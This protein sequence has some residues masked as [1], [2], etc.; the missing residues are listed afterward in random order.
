MPFI[1]GKNDKNW[2]FKVPKGMISDKYV[3]RFLEYIKFNELV[4][5]SQLNEKQALELSDEIKSSWW[6]KNK[7][8]I[9]K[10]M[11]PE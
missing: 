1:N 3:N 2:T 5:Q 10:N 4:Q 7:D 8:R 9:L 6:E 11:D